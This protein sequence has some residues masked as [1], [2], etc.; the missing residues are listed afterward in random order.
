MRP[1][2]ACMDYTLAG[3]ANGDKGRQRECVVFVVVIRYLVAVQASPTGMR[4]MSNG[5]EHGRLYCTGSC[6]K[7]PRAAVYG[8]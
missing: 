6:S 5:V 7:R 3:V 2:P 1:R 4:K 8:R